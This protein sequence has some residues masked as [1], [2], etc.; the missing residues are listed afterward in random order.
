MTARTL[1][2]KTLSYLGLMRVAEHERIAL[3][4]D[5]NAFTAWSKAITDR[6]DM[7]MQRDDWQAKH[8]SLLGKFKKA[9]SDLAA[10]ADELNDA[11]LHIDHLGITFNQRLADAVQDYADDALAM[12]KKRQADRDRIQAKRDAAKGAGK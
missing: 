9:V 6:D 1:L 5:D 12:R 10:Q 2:D 8:N 3:K 7:R 11:K 4:N